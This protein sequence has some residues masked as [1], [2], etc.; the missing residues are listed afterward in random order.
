MEDRKSRYELFLE[1]EERTAQPSKRRA[2]VSKRKYKS[3]EDRF[4][5]LYHSRCERVG[6]CLEWTGAKHGDGQPVCQWEGRQA[7]VRRVVYKLAIGEI[8]DDECVLMTCRNRLCVRHSHFTK[9]P[10]DDALVL[11][12]N[13]SAS[14]NR[15]GARTHPE[16]INW[17]FLKPEYRLRGEAHGSARLTEADV[18]AIRELY[19]AGGITQREIAKRFGIHQIHVSQIVTRKNWKHV[20]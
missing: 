10:K 6:D 19:A 5:K 12:W 14:G 16:K 20:Q 17:E 2:S 18:R 7:R 4:W 9:R 11:A 3:P 13:N 1:E 8:A 15:N